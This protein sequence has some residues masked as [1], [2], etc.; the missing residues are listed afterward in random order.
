MTGQ[1]A[2][3]TPQ[4]RCSSHENSTNLTAKWVG[5]K[6]HYSS[7]GQ[8]DDSCC[9]SLRMPSDKPCKRPAPVS[10]AWHHVIY[11]FVSKG[12]VTQIRPVLSGAVPAFAFPD[13]FWSA[14]T[15]L[16]SRISTALTPYFRVQGTNTLLRRQN[17]G[18]RAYTFWFSLTTSY[19]EY[20]FIRH[21]GHNHLQ[22][23]F[24]P[25]FAIPWPEISSCNWRISNLLRHMEGWS[26]DPTTGGA[27]QAVW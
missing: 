10:F 13:L 18:G 11:V 12:L 17:G 24:S 15:A 1:D 8:T 16:T 19:C 6:R 23:I 14:S 5:E 2:R 26:N 3:P 4:Q 22:D 7:S 27:A 20:F 21:I 9:R 25:S